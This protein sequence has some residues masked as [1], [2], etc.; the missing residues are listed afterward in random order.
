M[1]RIAAVL[2]AGMLIVFKEVPSLVKNKKRKELWVFSILLIAGCVLCIMVLMGIKVTTPL[3]WIKRIYEPI[4]K[5]IL[6]K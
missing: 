1:W 5:M 3:E 6:G 4:S 2:A